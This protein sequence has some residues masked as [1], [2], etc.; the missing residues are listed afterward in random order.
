M[1]TTIDKKETEI[2]NLKRSIKLTQCNQ[3]KVELAT[4]RQECVRL[5]SMAEQNMTSAKVAENSKAQQE[6]AIKVMRDQLR[7]ELSQNNEEFN[8]ELEEARAAN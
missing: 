3:L 5:R 8:E 2:A 1:Q 6:S 4:Y 7:Q